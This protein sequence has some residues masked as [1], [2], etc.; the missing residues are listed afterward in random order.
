MLEAP[1]DLGTGTSAAGIS[2]AYDNMQSGGMW[3]NDGDEMKRQGDDM[4]RS[5]THRY[6][7]EHRGNPE[8]PREKE[9]KRKKGKGKKVC[10][11]S[12]VFRVVATFVRAI[13]DVNGFVVAGC[14]SC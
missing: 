10:C 4:V 3:D 5:L 13:Q 6:H 7:V 8:R 11:N 2:D 9:K 1:L 12:E 14:R